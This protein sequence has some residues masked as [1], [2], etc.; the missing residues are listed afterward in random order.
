MHDD[1]FVRLNADDEQLQIFAL[2][3]RIDVVVFTTAPGKA[4][5]ERLP[6]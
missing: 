5:D 3:L 2:A 6:A 4:L 1:G